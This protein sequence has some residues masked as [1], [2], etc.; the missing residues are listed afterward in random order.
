VNP[1][2]YALLACPACGAAP[3]PDSRVCPGCGRALITPAGGLDLLDDESRTI[4]DEFQVNYRALRMSEGWADSAGRENPDTSDPSK[5]RV[6]VGLVLEAAAIVAKEWPEL[7]PVIADVGSGGGWAAKYFKTA[8]VIAIDLVEIESS[9]ALTVRGDMSKL[10]LRD[11]SVDAVLY[12]ASLHYAPVTGSIP[13]ARRVLRP[14]GLLVAVDS[15]VYRDPEAQA[16]A[17]RRS[18]AYYEKAGYRQLISHYHPID[19][20]RLRSELVS[21]GFQIERFDLGW[22]GRN[23]LRMLVNRPPASF[24]VAR[25]GDQAPPA[26]EGNLNSG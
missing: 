10:P 9:E 22:G 18:A 2:L 1:R 23:P 3:D 4:A 15:P 11:A 16:R 7:R 24:L 5:W 25:K 17:A 20:G 26:T 14:R 21:C 6:R 12:A 8:D 19:A 13:E